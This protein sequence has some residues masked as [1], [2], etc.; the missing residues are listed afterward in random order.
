MNEKTLVLG[1][2]LGTSGVR[3]AIINF[4]NQ[5]IHKSST[6][7]LDGLDKP[8][9]WIESCKLLIKQIPSDL[10]KNL[11]ACSIDGTSGTLLAC[12]NKGY[13]LGNALIYSHSCPEL[14][15]S[16]QKILKGQDN[17]LD[18]NSSLAR[19]IL[20][21]KKYGENILL[22]H[23]ADWVS[24]WLLDNWDLG[25]E[26]NNVRLGWDL[27][28]KS[29]PKSFELLTW[30]NSLPSIIKS[31]HLMG[32]IS[33]KKAK[34]LN[35]PKNLK[36]IAGTTDSNASVLAAYS[37]E[38][39][40]FSVLGSTLVIKRFVKNPI[41]GSGI[42][43]HLVG[44]KF[45]C[46][47]AS[48]AGGKVLE[49]FFSEKELRELSNQINPERN[50]GLNFLPLP[51]PG[52]RF[53]INDPYLQPIVSPRPTSDCLF[54]QGLLEGLAKIEAQGWKKLIELGVQP[55]KQIISIGSGAQNPQWRRIREKELGIPI[56]T[57]KRST[58]EGIAQLAMVSL[59]NV[60]A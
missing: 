40:G 3:I 50:S 18:V 59:K 57:C 2:D 32:N 21:I 7:Y 55:P 49:K 33:M 42:T 10:K 13:P 22:R 9:D 27:L 29:W 4:R 60:Q 45:L 46:G 56:Q 43:N 52:E 26:G 34:E 20:L 23:Q 53:P 44:G 6:K 39:D 17:S 5:L 54:L 48:N 28:Q 38:D 41:K 51:S 12:N 36:I 47:G 30:R 16:I 25:E 19:A 35:L 31:G 37:S 8:K 11:Q 24:G 1:I 14:K 15:E 58:A